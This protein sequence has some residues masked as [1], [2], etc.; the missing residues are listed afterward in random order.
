MTLPAY[1]STK[2][3]YTEEQIMVVEK[4]ADR[5]TGANYLTLFGIIIVLILPLLALAHILSSRRKLRRE[6][7]PGRASSASV[8]FTG[9]PL[10]TF[11]RYGKPADPINMQIHGAAGQIGGAVASAASYIADEIAF[12]RSART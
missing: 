1:T 2:E 9:T 3:H 6:S 7:Q 5:R 4:T 11:N 12:T 8:L 10:T